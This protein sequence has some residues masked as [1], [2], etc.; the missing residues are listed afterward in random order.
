M[1]N[2]LEQEAERLKREYGPRY[3]K[4]IEHNL[5]WVSEQMATVPGSIAIEEGQIALSMHL[6]PLN[7]HAVPKSRRRPI[8]KT[9]RKRI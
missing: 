7:R 4:I 1:I 8:H 3:H 6:P 5:D 9:S 2:L